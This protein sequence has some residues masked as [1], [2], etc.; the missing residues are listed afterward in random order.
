MLLPLCSAL[1]RPSPEML[2]PDL[3]SLVQERCGP[4]RAHPHKGHRNDPQNEIPSLQRY[5][6]RVVTV[7]TGEERASGK[8]HFGLLI[9]KESLKERNRLLS[10]VSGDKT[11]GNGFK[12]KKERFLL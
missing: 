5:A 10:R 4:G 9:S 11:K 7:Q 12:L 8:P 2:C 3:E 6:E 1:V